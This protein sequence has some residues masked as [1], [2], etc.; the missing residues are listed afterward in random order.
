VYASLLA[1]LV[2]GLRDAVEPQ[3]VAVTS[4]RR[5]HCSRAPGRAIE[6][7]YNV[8][9][10]NKDREAHEFRITGS[11]LPGLEVDYADPPCG[12][13]GAVQGVPVRIRCPRLA[14]GRADL[15]VASRP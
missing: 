6:N 8:K 13:P 12:S 10:L 1:L 5:N 4:S 11:G 9:I 15:E 2:T 7:V 3:R 14:A